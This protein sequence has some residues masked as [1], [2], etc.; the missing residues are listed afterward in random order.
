[1]L[2]F[3]IFMALFYQLIPGEKY[4]SFVK[5]MGGFLFLLLML[6]PVMGL[7][8][9]EGTFENYIRSFRFQQEN[10]EFVWQ[11]EHAGIQAYEP[12]IEEEIKSIV[13]EKKLN[14]TFCEPLWE[15]GTL[16]GIRL[17]VTYKRLGMTGEETEATPVVEAL[18]AEIAAV[19]ALPE[20]DVTVTL[21]E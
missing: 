4:K 19:Y 3:V 8:Q 17:G 5:L 7:F 12:L 2:I 20:K 18:K 9:M 16:T 14:L 1:M 15:S 11:L 6:S 10:R 13:T 21:E